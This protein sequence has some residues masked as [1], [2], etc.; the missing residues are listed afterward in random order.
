MPNLRRDRLRLVKSRSH[1]HTATVT[2]VP[3]RRQGQKADHEGR[4]VHERLR[5]HAC[6][7]ARPRPPRTP[8]GIPCGGTPC[9]ARWLQQHCEEMVA[10]MRAHLGDQLVIESPAT[11][12]ARRDGEIGTSVPCC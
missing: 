12:A 8:S 9:V 5:R 4:S 2:A 1:V 10:I 11:A 3:R 6:V 7:P